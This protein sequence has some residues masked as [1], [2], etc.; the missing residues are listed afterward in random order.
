MIN[1]FRSNFK[2]DNSKTYYL[3]AAPGCGYPGDSITPQIA[4]YMDYVWVQYYDTEY[5]LIGN[6]AFYNNIKLWSDNI[7][8]QL[9]VGAIASDAGGDIGYISANDLVTAL[10]KVKAMGLP[11]YSGAMLW[12][13]QLAANNNNYQKVV[14]AGL[15]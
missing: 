9:F 10:N 7:P 13:A 11:N 6:D 4:S 14:K 15:E 3:S 1:R 12:E 5:C 8:G 2:S